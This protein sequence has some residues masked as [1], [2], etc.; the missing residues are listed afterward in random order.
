MSAASSRKGRTMMTQ[1]AEEISAAKSDV[2]KVAVR[3]Q[4]LTLRH[5][6]GCGAAILVGIEAETVPVRW[7]DVWWCAQC[8]R[9]LP[10]AEIERQT[11]ELPLRGVPLN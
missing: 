5:C 9:N 3:G 10:A 4:P 2:G 6:D 8:M 1:V 11:R 7:G